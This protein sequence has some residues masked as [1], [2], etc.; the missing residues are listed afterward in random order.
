LSATI[1]PV[2]ID[3]KVIVLYSCPSNVCVWKTPLQYCVYHAEAQKQ[4]HEVH[5]QLS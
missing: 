5:S 3:G 4:L 1:F 2:S